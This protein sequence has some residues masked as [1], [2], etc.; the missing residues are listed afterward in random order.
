MSPYLVESGERCP[1]CSSPLF[2]DP[3][4]EEVEHCL[5]CGYA[6]WKSTCPRTK[7]TIRQPDDCRGCPFFWLDTSSCPF[8][9]LDTSASWG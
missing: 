8:L 1:E 4:L 9:R 6:R 3:S 5:S 7:R 2:K